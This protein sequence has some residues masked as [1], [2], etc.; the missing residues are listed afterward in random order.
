[1]KRSRVIA[2]LITT[3]VAAGGLTACSSDASSD[4][5]VTL[6]IMSVKQLSID[7][8]KAEIPASRP[9]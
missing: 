6:R 8:L 1:M 2:A 7:A 3:L 5:S 9:R 4:G